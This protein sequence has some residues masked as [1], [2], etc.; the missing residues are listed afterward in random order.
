[1]KIGCSYFGNRSVEHTR[2]DMEYLSRLGFTHVLHTLSE[3]DLC[4]YVDS[5]KEMVQISHEQG[6]EV[7]ASP[8]SVANIF[9]GEALSRFVA[10]YPQDCQMDST[11][12]R[13]PAAC[14]NQP[15]LDQYMIRWLETAKYIGVDVIFWDEPHWMLIKE[16]EKNW[17]CR[18]ATCQSLFEQ[19]F[20]IPMPVA[21]TAQV[22]QFRHNSM[23]GKLFDWSTQAKQLGMQVAVCLLPGI[24]SEEDE[25]HWHHVCA[26]PA[27]DILATDPY[28]FIENHRDHGF[29]NRILQGTQAF[30]SYYSQKV[31]DLTNKYGKEGQIW[32]QNFNI[33]AGQEKEVQIAVETAH[34]AGIRNLFAWGF[35][36]CAYMSHTRCANSELAW[37]SFVEPVRK[38][39]APSL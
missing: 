29:D 10:E 4:F 1:M 15:A 26:H 38:L 2:T 13:Y 27:V 11:G 30:V 31:M 18:C 3:D 34:Q 7:Y 32:I 5:L 12:R 9:G 8:W 23:S 20:G 6:L 14:L 35:K 22:H 28:P 39:R 25:E 21:Y 36:G 19:E 24:E 37:Q 33:P 17:T 16:K